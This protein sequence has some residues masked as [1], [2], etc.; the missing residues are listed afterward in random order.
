M[1]RISVITPTW[2]R[3]VLLVARCVPSVQA[4]T[5]PDVEHVVVSDGP[6]SPLKRFLAAQEVPGLVYG[7]VPVH[8][9][10]DHNW[11]SAARNHAAKL[12]TG[13]L[14]AYLDDDN[15]YRPEH[16]KTLAEALLTDP[17]VDFAY[18]QM[19]TH[20]NEHVIGDVPP[21]YGQIDTSLI[22]HRAGLLERCGDWPLAGQI[23]C[24]DQHAPDWGVVAKWLAAGATWLHVPQVTVDYWSA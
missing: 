21:E 23:D 9:D 5:W 20:P 24:H 14:V 8:D 13:D 1:T 22:M 15:A 3:H 16:L 17:D 18:S 6:D 10:S 12:A 7:E 19:L 2:K 11:G 4:Q